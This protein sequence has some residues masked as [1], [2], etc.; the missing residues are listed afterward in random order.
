MLLGLTEVL[1]GIRLLGEAVVVVVAVV[2]AAAAAAGVVGAAID[3]REL[4]YTVGLR[5]VPTRCLPGV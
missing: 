4:I 1:D 5:V 3:G 2:A